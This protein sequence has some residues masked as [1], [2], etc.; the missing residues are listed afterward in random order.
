M[1]KPP[2]PSRVRCAV[3]TRKSSE[4]GLE[5]AFNSL[6]AQREACESYILSQ[7]HEGWSIINTLYDDGGFSGGTMERPALQQLLEDIKTGRIDIVVVYKIDRLTRSL[8][9][10][11]K[12]VEIFDAHK[13]SFVS[14]T[15]SFNTTTSMGRL[16]LNVLLSFAQFEREVTGERIRDKFAASKKKG[17][18]M[19]GPVPLGYDIKDRKLVINLAEAKTVRQI[20]DLYLQLGAV[21][22]LKD[23]ADRLALKTKLHMNGHG[24]SRGGHPVRIGHLY[25]ILRNSLY[26]GL[27]AHKGQSYP[28]DHKPIIN[29]DIWEKVQAQLTSNAQGRRSGASAREPSLLVGL[30][31][32]ANGK[33]MT[34][35]HAVKNGKR[36]RYYL[37]NNLIAGKGPGIR[38]AAHEIENPIVHEISGLLM[39]EAKLVKILFTASKDPTMVHETLVKAKVL[40]QQITYG[41]NVEKNHLIQQLI[42][43]IIL[44]EKEIRIV[45]R[46]SVLANLC[47]V[48]MVA[49]ENEELIALK[50]EAA[51]RRLGNVKKLIVADQANPHNPDPVLIKAVVRAHRWFEMLKTRQLKSISKIAAAEKLS[52]TYVGSLLP[53]AFLAPDITEAILEGYQPVGFTLDRV[54]AQPRLPLE[55]TAQRFA[56]GFTNLKA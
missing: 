42:E 55:W 23:Q 22:K 36:Y 39:D 20:F 41:T 12:I 6:H 15:Q 16:T 24:K 48:E 14:V 49:L 4:E 25:T 47:G 19:G 9:D 2:S 43:Q 34:P 1:G 10:F 31:F 45:V 35:S 13:V 40:S 44:S 28:G 30:L 5:Q 26:V 56:L 53:L 7:R 21:R 27:I 50:I 54:L 18:W 38:I 3:Y 17:M 52:R 11:A 33:R 46:R 29:R 51:L 37:S 8:F 32:D